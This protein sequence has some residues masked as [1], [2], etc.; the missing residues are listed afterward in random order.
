[1]SIKESDTK[2]HLEVYSKILMEQPLVWEQILG[3]PIIVNSMSNQDAILTKLLDSY[4]MVLYAI[5]QLLLEE[6]HL[7]ENLMLILMEWDY[8][9]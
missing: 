5:P 9:S 8:T 2:F 1:M 3:P 4:T 6:F 7:L